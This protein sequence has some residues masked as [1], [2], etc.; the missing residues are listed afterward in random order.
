MPALICW[1]VTPVHSYPIEDGRVRSA[2]ASM[3]AIAS[4]VLLPGAGVPEIL[5]VGYRL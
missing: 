4:P 2:S 3:A 1:K 5:V